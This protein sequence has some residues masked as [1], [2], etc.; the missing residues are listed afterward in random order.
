MVH[1]CTWCCAAC[2]IHR[3]C[4]TPA[5][6]RQAQPVWMSGAR[7]SQQIQHTRLARC[8]CCRCVDDRRARKRRSRQRRL[9]LRRFAPI[10][11]ERRNDTESLN[12]HYCTVVHTGG[13]RTHR[14]PEHDTG[15][16][17]PGHT[18]TCLNFT[19]LDLTCLTCLTS[20]H[21]DGVEG[22]KCVRHEAPV[23]WATSTSA[24]NPSRT[25]QTR[26][27]RRW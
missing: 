27:R 9:R 17:E 23:T 6:P 13:R 24:M 7:P 11:P 26:Q 12:M 22:S 2:T 18:R 14:G 20:S 3:T 21:P 1:R 5:E 4:A 16:S 10:R 15:G 8:P 25:N 19:R